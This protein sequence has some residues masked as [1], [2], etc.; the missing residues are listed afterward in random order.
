MSE[1]I[2]RF[3]WLQVDCADPGT[4]A[5]FWAAALGVAVRGELT[6]DD[7]RPQYVF[8]DGTADAAPRLSFQRVSEPKE[9][10]NRLHIDLAVPDVGAATAALTALGASEVPGGDVHEHDMHW[11][12]LADPEGN[13]FCLVEVPPA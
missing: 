2:G 12:V 3:G 4:L 10:K 11:R 1:Q 7:G 5:A 6:G 8:L 9:G 13:E